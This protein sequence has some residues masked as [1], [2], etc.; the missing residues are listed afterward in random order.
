MSAVADPSTVTIPADVAER[1][2]DT[3]CGALTADV[4]TA[5]N[6]VEVDVLAELLRA[7]GAEQA[8]D[9]W[10]AAHAEADTPGDDHFQGP[11]PAAVSF[12]CD[13]HHW[14]P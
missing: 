12:D 3:W 4:A 11:V 13:A 10:T 14:R 2:T 5:L 8:A 7:L 1:F 6:C 9:E